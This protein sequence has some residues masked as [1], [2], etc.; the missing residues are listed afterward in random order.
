MIGVTC[1]PFRAKAAQF[2]GHLPPS[3]LAP[4]TLERLQ[5][6]QMPSRYLEMLRLVERDPALL[7]IIA[8]PLPAHLCLLIECFAP[9]QFQRILRGE[10]HISSQTLCHHIPGSSYQG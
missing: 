6:N 10:E 7:A 3:E 9:L 8:H 2:S 5:D 1:S 4:T